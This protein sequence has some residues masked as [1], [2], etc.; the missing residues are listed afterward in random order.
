MICRKCVNCDKKPAN[1]KM[2]GKK[3]VQLSKAIDRADSVPAGT[4]IY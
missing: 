3:L 1:I 4:I 2:M